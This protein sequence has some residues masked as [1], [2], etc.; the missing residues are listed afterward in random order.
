MSSDLWFVLNI[1][2]FPRLYVLT[3]EIEVITCQ[4]MAVLLNITAMEITKCTKLQFLQILGYFS[5]IL[6]FPS[7][8]C[9]DKQS[10]SC[11]ISSQYF[12]KM[13]L[14]QR[15]RAYQPIPN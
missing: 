13:L 14:I 7:I 6:T 8:V 10:G 1:L 11:K 2:C 9:V 15:H 5:N 4:N 12:S 3:S